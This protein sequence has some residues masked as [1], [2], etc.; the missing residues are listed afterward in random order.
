MGFTHNGELQIVMEELTLLRGAMIDSSIVALFSF[1]GVEF[2][3]C[4]EQ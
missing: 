4:F 1:L 2:F 3:S